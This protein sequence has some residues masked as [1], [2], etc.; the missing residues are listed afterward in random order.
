MRVGTSSRGD[1]GGVFSKGVNS[2]WNDQSRDNVLPL[3]D[4]PGKEAWNVED[5]GKHS[6]T[7]EEEIESTGQR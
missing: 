2:D 4:S 7:R 5:L 1:M 3:V 6:H